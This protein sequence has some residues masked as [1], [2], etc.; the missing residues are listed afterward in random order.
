VF[1]KEPDDLQAPLFNAGLRIAHAHVAQA[2]ST[3][4][5]RN[6]HEHPE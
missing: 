5:S 3:Q 1:F 4:A 2:S 6:R